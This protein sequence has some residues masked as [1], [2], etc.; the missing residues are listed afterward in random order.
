MY[1]VMQEK[2]PRGPLMPEEVMLLIRH[3][4]QGDPAAASPFNIFN[5]SLVLS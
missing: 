3:L 1:F 2:H 5:V 4:L